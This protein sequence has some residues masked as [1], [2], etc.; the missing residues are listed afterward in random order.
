MNTP[1]KTYEE[2]IAQFAYA[3]TGWL[4][5]RDAWNAA[6]ASLQPELERLRKVEEAGEGVVMSTDAV[7]DIIDDFHGIAT[8]AP[9][10]YAIDPSKMVERI[11]ASIS[12]YQKSVEHWREAKGTK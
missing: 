6:I 1:A 10:S 2:W 7:L 9:R 5:A 3:G 11:N 4:G 12:D 8:K